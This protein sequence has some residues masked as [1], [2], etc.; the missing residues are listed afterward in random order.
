[1]YPSFA[2]R[3]FSESIFSAVHQFIEIVEHAVPLTKSLP[4]SGSM[5]RPR[6]RRPRMVAH[7]SFGISLL[8]LPTSP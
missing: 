2:L 7:L 6:R 8:F 1:M 5:R 4:F 3:M